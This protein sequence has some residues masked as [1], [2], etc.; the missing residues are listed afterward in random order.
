MPLTS[1]RLFIL[2]KIDDTNDENDDNDDCRHFDL[3]RK[4]NM[5]PKHT[6]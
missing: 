3:E 2:K 4:I 1:T 5:F 6:I